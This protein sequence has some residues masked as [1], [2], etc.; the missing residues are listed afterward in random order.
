M[1]S[2]AL[3][4]AAA[5]L[6]AAAALTGLAACPTIDLGEDPS[7]PAVCRPDPTYFRD[8]IWP[9]FLAPA[10]ASKSCVAAA[11]CHRQAD[12]RSALRLDADMDPD[13]D[14]NY[15]VTVRF[16]NCGTPAASPLLTKPV[17]GQDSHG[18]GDLFTSSDPAVMAFE[19]WF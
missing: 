15:D 4:R 2:P 12:G 17:A 13:L 8:V 9:Q 7:N 3:P 18:G 11:G 5:T 16:L 1:G 14:R 6:A 19:G 10:D